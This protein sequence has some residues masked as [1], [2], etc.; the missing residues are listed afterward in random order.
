MSIPADILRELKK[1]LGKLILDS[2]ITEEKIRKEIVN[3]SHKIIAV[4]DHSTDKLISFEIFPDLAIVDGIERRQKK[5]ASLIDKIFLLEGRNTTRISCI[6][7]PGSITEEAIIS[8]KFALSSSKNFILQ[9]V[10]EEDLLTLPACYFAPNNSM[11]CY[12]QPLK[13]LVLVKVNDSTRRKAKELM[14]S[15]NSKLLTGYDD[16]VAV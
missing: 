15:I 3:N 14:K 6:N 10:G 12:G 16:V 5:S 9:V 11:V 2:D 7:P 4:G 8:I 1:P 13:G